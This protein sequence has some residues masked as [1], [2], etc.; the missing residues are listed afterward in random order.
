VHS[1]NS[2]FSDS[3][4]VPAVREI[5]ADPHRRN[6]WV[7]ANPSRREDFDRESEFTRVNSDGRDLRDDQHSTKP[8]S[9]ANEQG[10]SFRRDASG[11]DGVVRG[12]NT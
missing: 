8:T 1:V 5:F 4:P 9:W 11:R 12:S 2:P 3:V 10:V 6:A 7:S